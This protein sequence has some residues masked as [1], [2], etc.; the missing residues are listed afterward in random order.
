[1]QALIKMKRIRRMTTVETSNCKSVTF[2]D[3]Y[4]S[5]K[6]G[7]ST[8]NFELCIVSPIALI[9][10]LKIKKNNFIPIT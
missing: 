9:F 10:Y 5:N 6:P 7:Y 3:K 1:M 8:F 2:Y 4:Y